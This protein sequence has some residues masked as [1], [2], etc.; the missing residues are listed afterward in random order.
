MSTDTTAPTAR[1]STLGSRE[2][3]P[4]PFPMGAVTPPGAH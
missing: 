2:P 3:E 4:T 1:A